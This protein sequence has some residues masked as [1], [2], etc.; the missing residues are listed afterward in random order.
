LLVDEV[1]HE[2]E[3]EDP[4]AGGEVLAAVVHGASFPLDTRV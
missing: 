4:D 2:G 1:E 3:V